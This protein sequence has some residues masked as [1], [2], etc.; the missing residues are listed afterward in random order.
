MSKHA[1]VFMISGLSYVHTLHVSLL[2][3]LEAVPDDGA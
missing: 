1:V 2:V 3:K